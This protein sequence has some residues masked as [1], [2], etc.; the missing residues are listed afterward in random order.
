MPLI[1]MHPNPHHLPTSLLLDLLF[2]GHKLLIRNIWPIW[3]YQDIFAIGS[4]RLLALLPSLFCVELLGLSDKRNNRFPILDFR[5]FKNSPI[6]PRKVG[7]N[8]TGFLP[9]IVSAIMPETVGL[10]LLNVCR[11]GTFL[12]FHLFLFFRRIASVGGGPGGGETIPGIQYFE[13]R[14]GARCSYAF[15]IGKLVSSAR[16]WLFNRHFSAEFNHFY[17]SLFYFNHFSNSTFVTVRILLHS[18]RE[19]L[20][21]LSVT[22]I[23]TV[24]FVKF[25][26]DAKQ[27]FLSD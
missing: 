10:G 9:V 13:T 19:N 14:R 3:E 5:M 6:V 8:V 24:D 25:R 4:E 1:E 23:F 27:K 26:F 12:A 18:F 21:P 17:S 2:E 20:W 7:F 11:T 22:T 16:S 15:S